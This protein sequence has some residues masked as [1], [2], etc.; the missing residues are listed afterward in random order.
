[1]TM[2]IDKGNYEGWL[3]R[4]DAI[5]PEVISPDKERDFTFD[6]NENPFVVEGQ[7]WD[8]ATKTSYAIKY[9]D[10][11]YIITKHL[12]T[13]EELNNKEN[14]KYFIPHRLDGI[15]SIKMLQYWKE[16]EDPE[17]ENFKVLVPWKLVFVG[18][19]K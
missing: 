9:V 14:K 5:K 1:M 8:A 15:K 4:S 10:G 3:W 17:C 18:F 6:D 2:T 13:D 7:L 19:Q 16:E 12:V 11:K